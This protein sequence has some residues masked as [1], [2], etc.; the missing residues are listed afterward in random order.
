MCPD[1]EKSLYTQVR[2]SNSHIFGKR[3]AVR[4]NG[5]SICHSYWGTFEQIVLA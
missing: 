1:D 2:I 4:D 3:K 5:L